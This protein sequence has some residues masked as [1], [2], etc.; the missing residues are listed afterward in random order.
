MKQCGVEVTCRFRNGQ[1]YMT[2]LA[3]HID[4][5]SIY[6]RQEEI[7]TLHIL[8]SATIRAEGCRIYCRP[9]L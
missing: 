2:V 1:I 5:Q 3:A 4:A 7:F 6:C 9:T 8:S